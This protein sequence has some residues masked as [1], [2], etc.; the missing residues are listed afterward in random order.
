LPNPVE[1]QGKVA[2]PDGRTLTAG[3]VELKPTGTEGLEAFGDID[4]TGSFKLTTFK[5]G[6]G[7]VPGTYKVT[8]NPFQFRTRNGI[9]ARIPNAAQIPPRYLEASSSDL[10]VQIKPGGSQLDLRLNR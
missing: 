4:A 10:T 2:L 7:A 6:D 1:A 8:I 9:P 3:R 5:P